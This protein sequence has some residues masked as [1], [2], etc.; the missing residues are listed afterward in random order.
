MLYFLVVILSAN[1]AA[2]LLLRPSAA[3]RHLHQKMA[4]VGRAAAS[5][6]LLYLLHAAAAAAS[7]KDIFYR[8][9]CC[10]FY[11]NIS[12]TLCCSKGCIQPIQWCKFVNFNKNKQIYCFFSP[13]FRVYFMLSV[14]LLLV[15]PTSLPTVPL[16]L[17]PP[18]SPQP[19]ALPTLILLNGSWE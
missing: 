6:A 17:D 15:W 10:R 2:R 3:V 1:M 12:N 9:S 8:K 13:N 5:R 18:P 11:L 4:A 14:C 16:I 7:I 19:M